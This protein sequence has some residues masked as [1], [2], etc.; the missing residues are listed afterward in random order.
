MF[1]EFRG[2]DL[3]NTGTGVQGELG[4]TQHP[5]PTPLQITDQQFL[6]HLES[7]KQSQRLILDWREKSHYGGLYFLLFVLGTTFS[8]AQGLILVLG[9]RITPGNVQRTVCGTG[10]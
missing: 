3:G 9:L 8:S 7:R 10:W 6:E 5:Q 1:T 2:S 4:H